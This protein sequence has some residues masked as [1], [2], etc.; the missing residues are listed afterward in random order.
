LRGPGDD[1][2]HDVVDGVNFRWTAVV[3]GEKHV[4]GPD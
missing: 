4:R 1:C 2:N 3:I